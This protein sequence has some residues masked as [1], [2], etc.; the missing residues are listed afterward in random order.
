[1]DPVPGA[2]AAYSKR[3]AEMAALQEKTKAV[4]RKGLWMSAVK[5]VKQSKKTSTFTLSSTVANT[6]L[7]AN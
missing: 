5:S 3:L 1:M 4:E 2:S 6:K 7:R